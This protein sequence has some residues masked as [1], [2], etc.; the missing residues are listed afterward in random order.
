MSTLCFFLLLGGGAYAAGHLGKNTIGS[1]QL[2]KNAVT[3][4]KVKDDSLTG[5]DINEATLG[6]IP[7]ATQADQARHA[8]AAG[9]ADA[10]GGVPAGRY[11]TS[12]TEP[13]RLIGTAGNPAFENTFKNFG[14]GYAPA[15]FYKDQF[16]IVHLQGFVAPPGF[17]GKIFT[18]PEGYR[19]SQSYNFT[20]FGAIADSEKIVPVVVSL[21]GG[22][23]AVTSNYSNSLSLNGITFRAES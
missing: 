14:P 21:T 6:T 20:Y 19:P 7:S 23:E 18:L 12:Q 22:V 3:G 11:V 4:A 9:N 5:S 16:G 17:A 1:K 2:K 15:G 13:V 10:L 8:D